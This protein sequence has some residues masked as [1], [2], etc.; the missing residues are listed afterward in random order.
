[1]ETIFFASFRWGNQQGDRQTYFTEEKSLKEFYDWVQE[2][3][4]KIEKE[5]KTNCTVI[6]IQKL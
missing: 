3:R 2:H 4:E 1:M 6:S 5:F